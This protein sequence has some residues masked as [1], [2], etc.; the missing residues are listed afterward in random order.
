MN[1]AIRIPMNRQRT[2]GK[3]SPYLVNLSLLVLLSFSAVSAQDQG[4]PTS[5]ATARVLLQAQKLLEEAKAD[6]AIRI[7]R[8]ADNTKSSESAIAYLLGV[9][10]HLKG[11]YAQAVERLSVAVKLIPQK[12]AKYR[13]A[14]Q[15]LGLS[16]YVL[17][18]PV[19]AIPY[20]E[21]TSQFLPDSAEVA[22]ALGSCYIQ[23]RNRDKSRDVF[24]RMFKV[25]ASSASAYLINAQMIMRQQFE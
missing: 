15:I 4:V 6:E 8:S 18:H 16:H 3:L 23:T 19:D 14:I 10:Y 1:L 9:A 7:L 11:D 21:E 13:N 2:M 20:L 12:D 17:G 24:A 25:P 5:E 22:Y